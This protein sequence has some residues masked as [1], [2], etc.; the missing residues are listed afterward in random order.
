MLTKTQA[1]ILHSYFFA[2]F[3]GKTAVIACPTEERARRTF[4]EAKEL[5][6]SVLFKPELTNGN[7]MSFTTKNCGEFII[8]YPG[9]WGES[10]ISRAYKD[11]HLKMWYEGRNQSRRLDNEE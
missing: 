9:K 2:L 11:W 3:M 8:D 4:E 6:S 10:P 7:A 1:M 5:L